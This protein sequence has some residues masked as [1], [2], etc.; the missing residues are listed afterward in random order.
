[1]EDLF[2]TIAEYAALWTPALA[3]I[4]GIVVTVLTTISR[5]NEAL[6]TLKADT[7]LSQLKSDLKR[8]SA[9]NEE[10]VK[11]NKLLLDQITKIQ[12]YADHKEL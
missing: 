7:T 3:G 10:L 4:L 6:K 5:L 11:C 8:I 12:G 2:I 9:Q 1:M